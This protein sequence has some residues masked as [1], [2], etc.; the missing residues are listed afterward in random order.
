MFLSADSATVTG[1]ITASAVVL[2]AFITVGG[3]V[4]IT[5]LNASTA[6]RQKEID[7]TQKLNDYRRQLV[8]KR[9]DERRDVYLR[10]MKAAQEARTVVTKLLHESGVDKEKA[11]VAMK[12]VYDAYDE[13]AILDC[14]DDLVKVAAKIQKLLWTAIADGRDRAVGRLL[15]EVF[16]RMQADLS[17]DDDVISPHHRAPET[18]FD[19][20]DVGRS[21]HTG[22]D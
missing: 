22:R 5:R 4:L 11:F 16:N 10:W 13:L 21:G 8:E 1:L 17:R 3:N 15:I 7:E 9:R 19:L 2:T 6:Q 18:R 14:P 20:S 12:P